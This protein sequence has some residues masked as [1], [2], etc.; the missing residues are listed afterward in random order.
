MLLIGTS[1]YDYP[2]WKGVFYPP[3]LK[4]AEF[5]SFY[6]E[7]FN[8]LE[9]N[10]SFY[11]MPTAEQLKRMAERS[12]KRVKI[13]IKANQQLTHYIE[14]GAWREAAREFR[15]ALQPLQE[16]NL[17]SAVLFQFPQAF[18]R[19]EDNRRYLANLLEEFPDH[20]LI[21]EFRHSSWQVAQVYQSL[22]ERGV[23]CCSCDMPE[24][25][26]LPKFTPVL[27]G[28]NAYMR[29][30]GRNAQK[31]YGTN[32]RDRYEY[33]YSEEELSGYVPVLKDISEKSQT[34]HIFFNNHAKGH[35]AVNAQKMMILLAEG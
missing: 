21:V 1:G 13:S 4:R 35:A 33:N 25:S 30:H 29:F 31:W 10:F 14:L 7:V 20:P 32:S 8:A 27:T 22:E 34:L 6:S 9:L 26:K 28:K 18:H 3:T 19:G 24:I 16:E 11:T 15:S 2:E 17:L 5:L 23:T 12:G